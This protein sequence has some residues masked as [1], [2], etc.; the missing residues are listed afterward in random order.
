MQ[1]KATRKTI[2]SQKFSLAFLLFTVAFSG[3]SKS[4]DSTPSNSSPAII[5]SSSNAA[6]PATPAPTN[7]QAKP[8]LDACTLLTSAD[9]QAVHREGVKKTKPSGQAT[10]G[11]DIAQ[12]FYSL[13]TFTNSISLLIAQKGEGPDASN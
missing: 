11:L 12:C 7:S 3:C 4:S 5:A 6:T 2:M 10:G 8:K 9:I 13:P 1:H